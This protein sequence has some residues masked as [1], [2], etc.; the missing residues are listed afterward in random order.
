[1]FYVF[2]EDKTA[3]YKF[4][5]ALG[6]EFLNLPEENIIPCAGVTK[7]AA[8]IKSTPLTSRDTVIVPIDHT[9]RSQYTVV[10]EAVFREAENRSFGVILTAYYCFESY[11]L[12]FK[13][14]HEWGG[15]TDAKILSVFQDVY[16]K[17]WAGIDWFE[18]LDSEYKR[19]WSLRNPERLAKR[20]LSDVTRESGDSFHI[21]ESKLGICWV[22]DCENRGKLCVD[23][24][25]DKDL[26]TAK[27]K[28]KYVLNNSLDLL[29]DSLII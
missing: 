8:K 29:A 6:R 3:G 25:M 21:G 5:Q 1:M 9:G 11:L 20:L 15:C 23:C 16:D 4:W 14:V 19:I 2:C 22:S 7:I 10:L 28:L 13:K 26:K 12:S 27:L 17:L 24:R 18:G